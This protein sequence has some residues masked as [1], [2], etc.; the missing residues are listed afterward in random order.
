[1]RHALSL[2]LIALITVTTA[3]PLLAQSKADE[4]ELASYT[5]T[6]ATMKRV[7]AAM[8]GMTQEMMNDP[9]YQQ[10]M[11]FDEQIADLEKQID[12][13]QQKDEMTDAESAK[14]DSLQEQ[15]EK[16]RERKEQAEESM[17]TNS[18]SMNNA[19]SLDEME[20]AIA[21]FAPMARALKRE[22]LTP[23]EY[24]K[25]TLAMLQAG[26]IHGMSQGKVDYAK[27]PAG[28]NPENVKFIAAHQAELE[29]MQKEFAAMG[30]P[31][32]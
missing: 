18:P 13:L 5:L 4:K 3:A 12:T 28:V 15:V 7:V 14:A 2:I 20:R 8:R 22:S 6:L 9:K 27:L 31:K 26:M 19:Q 23:R 32:N 17:S 16:L 21:A 10:L 30:K 24:A 11:K 29:A 25:F 1:M